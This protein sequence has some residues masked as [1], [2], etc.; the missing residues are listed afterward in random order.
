MPPATAKRSKNGQGPHL[1]IDPKKVVLS[2]K[3]ARKKRVDWNADE[4]ARLIERGAVIKRD[5][6]KV[7]AMSMIQALKRAQNDVMTPDRR[8]NLNSLSPDNYEWFSRGV[9]AKL[10]APEPK[11][12]PPPPPPPPTLESLADV[13]S[14]LKTTVEAVAG[15]TGEVRGLADR[16]RPMEANGIVMRR[17]LVATMKALDPTVLESLG[18]TDTS[19][20]EAEAPS[21]GQ[22][23]T[24]PKAPPKFRVCVVGGHPSTQA[25]IRRQVNDFAT[26]T[27]VLEEKAKGYRGDF[28]QFDAVLLTPRTTHE[29]TGR[30][31]AALG[32]GAAIHVRGTGTRSIV[33]AITSAHARR[34]NEK[35][36]R[37]ERGG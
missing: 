17:I 19:E 30:A 10:K 25:E 21:N 24:A 16:L 18:V 33:E 5:A 26:V 6:D 3:P 9:A 1:V 36:R 2:A 4:K 13:I 28:K 37:Q 20:A 8:R 27:F 23:A 14:V 11:P 7:G 34:E 31:K 15:L 29:T 35:R 22:V 12:E 32:A